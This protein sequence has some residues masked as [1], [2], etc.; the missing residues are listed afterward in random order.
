MG[1]AYGGTM[2]TQGRPSAPPGPADHARPVD[3]EPG[4]SSAGGSPYRVWVEGSRVVVA[5]S[6][7]ACGADRLRHVLAGAPSGREVT[8]DL[9]R[10]AFADAAGCRALASW[11]R[12]RIARGD[13][14][15]LVEA[16]PFLARLWGLLGYD[17]VAPV[18][19]RRGAA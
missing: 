18:S 6:V 12:D 13:R 1:S 15:A 4:A 3:D 11:A 16:S 8:L 2:R 7:D 9:G 10:P 14:V 17:A 5:G 19:V